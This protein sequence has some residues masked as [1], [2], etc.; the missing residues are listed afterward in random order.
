MHIYIQMYVFNY[1]DV[2]FELSKY[3][4][5]ILYTEVTSSRVDPFQTAQF[6]QSLRLMRAFPDH[7]PISLHRKVPSGNLT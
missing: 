4:Y 6:S 1:T 7:H 3:Q 2:Y 5:S